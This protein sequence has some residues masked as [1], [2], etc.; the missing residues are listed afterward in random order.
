FLS[1]LKN[2]KYEFLKPLTYLTT[3]TYL[4]YLEGAQTI[5]IRG[6]KRLVRYFNTPCG[7]RKHTL[8]G[9]KTHLMGYKN[10]PFFYTFGVVLL[11][12]YMIF[13]LT[14]YAYLT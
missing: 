14:K 13:G 3:L 2:K 4:T 11:M 8:W 7:V 9:T 1:L 6:R 12:I 10:T 5:A